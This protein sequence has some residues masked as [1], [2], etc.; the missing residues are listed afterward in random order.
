MGVR[1]VVIKVGECRDKGDRCSNKGGR[2]VLIR[3]GE[4]W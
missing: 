4:V 3:V 1:S 2:N